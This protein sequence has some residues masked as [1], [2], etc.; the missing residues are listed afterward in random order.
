MNWL[1][2]G[3][4]EKGSQKV[5]YVGQTSN[6]EYRRYKHEKYDPYHENLSE[7]DYPLS[8]GIRKHG[9]EYYEYF[10]IEKDIQNDM[11]AI[12]REAFWINFYNTYNQGFNQ[13]SGG[14]APKYIKFDKEIIELAK[15]M[16]KDKFS[17]NDIAIETGISVPHLS[18]IN[19]GKRHHDDKENYP[20]NSMTCG[21]LLSNQDIEE[22][23]ELL[24]NTKISQKVIGEKFNVTQTCISKINLGKS[25][26]NDNLDYP[27]RK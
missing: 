12:E 21:R 23:V 9:I 20:L 26:K 4:K 16:L 27:I 17:F 19:T 5:C 25:Y 10:I 22:I 1:I 11:E 13:T 8:R 7:Y 14:K 24:K 18:E 15:Q 3:Y 2:Y 6:E